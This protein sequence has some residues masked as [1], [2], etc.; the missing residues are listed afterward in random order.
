[1]LNA[2]N[3]E[4]ILDKELVNISNIIDVFLVSDSMLMG[5]T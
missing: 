4:S 2:Y 1:M 3:E 5:V